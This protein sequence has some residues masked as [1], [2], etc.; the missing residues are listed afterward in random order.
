M[1]PPMSSRRFIIDASGRPLR[2]PGADSRC[3]SVAVT[4]TTTIIPSTTTGY[5]P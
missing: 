2:Q 4:S 1:L 5:T 3:A